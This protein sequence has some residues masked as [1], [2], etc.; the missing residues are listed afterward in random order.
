[1]QDILTESQT[2]S[3]AT[4]KQV[5]IHEGPWTGIN[6]TIAW[7]LYFQEQGLSPHARCAD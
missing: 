6:M 4:S 2:W 1:M 3:I 5:L 7:E